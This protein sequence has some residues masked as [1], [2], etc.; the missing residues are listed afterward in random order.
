M[1]GDMDYNDQNDDEEED[2]EDAPLIKPTCYD[3]AGYGDES[4]NDNDEEEKEE[5]DDEKDKDDEEKKDEDYEELVVDSDKEDSAPVHLMEKDEFANETFRGPMIKD[6][7][8]TTTADNDDSSSVQNSNHTGAGGESKT[9]SRLST[10]EKI[11]DLKDQNGKPEDIL[12]TKKQRS[13]EVDKNYESPDR[14][15]NPTGIQE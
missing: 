9:D 7:E 5:G 12:R 15:Y 3:I 13:G 11:D 10:T 2:D 1:Q 8:K 4:S 6:S 14:S